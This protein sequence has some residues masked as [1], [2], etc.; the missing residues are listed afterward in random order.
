MSSDGTK[1]AR[2]T[3]TKSVKGSKS[4]VR[5]RC[6]P[7]HR[8]RRSTSASPIAALQRALG[9]RGASK[10]LP[11]IA[12]AS[13][14]PED[15]D[16]IERLRIHTAPHAASVADDAGAQAF[17]VAY[18][19]VF[20]EG[21]F[22]SGSASGRR[23]LAHEIAH[24][25]QQTTEGL[26]VASPQKAEADADAYAADVVAGRPAHVEC[27]TPVRFAAQKKEL[28]IP[29]PARGS[30][31]VYRESDGAFVYVFNAED[32]RAWPD[33]LGKTFATYIADAFPGATASIATEYLRQ[34][35]AT[36]IEGPGRETM[37]PQARI[38]RY[39]AKPDFHALV[40]EWMKN[41]HPQ[42]TPKPIAVGSR[43]LPKDTPPAAG[44]SSSTD[45]PI[46]VEV[47]GP[48]PVGR[49]SNA[50]PQSGEPSKDPTQQKKSDEG[51]SPYGSPKGTDPHGI[52][53]FDPYGQLVI[54][55]AAGPYVA[56]SKAKARVF[57]DAS[58]LWNYALNIFPHHA[59]FDWAL[60][61]D[62]KQID[63]NWGIQTGRIE[64]FIDFKEPGTYVVSVVVS[65]HQFKDGKTLALSS[66]PLVVVSEKVREKE[67]FE[68]SLVGPGAYKP[69]VRDERGN[70]RAKPGFVPRSIQSEI[71]G[72][73][74]ALAAIDQ[75]RKD[76]RISEAEAQRSKNFFNEQLENLKT[77]EKRVGKKS[78]T[79]YG[80][81]L[82]RENSSSQ[83][84][85]VF[86]NQT[87][88][89][90]TTGKHAYIDVEFYDSTAS[91][92][93]RRSM[94]HGE[95]AT[96]ADQPGAYADA[97]TQAIYN[98]AVQWQQYNEYP[99][100]T[101]HFAVQLIERNG[102]VRQWTFDTHTSR[103][104]AKEWIS[105]AAAVGG[106][107]LLAASVVTGGATAPVGVLL[108]ESAVAGMTVGL[109]IASLEERLTTGTFHF[110]ARFVMDMTALVTAFVGVGATMR[111]LAAPAGV[112]SNAN[113]GTRML[114]FNVGAGSFN[115]A[116]MT[117]ETRTLIDQE[118]ASY[119]AAIANVTDEAQKAD[120]EEKHRARLAGIMGAACVSGGIILVATAVA[121]HSALSPKPSVQEPLPASK[122]A[123][124]GVALDA[125]PLP[126]TQ[127]KAQ[128]DVVPPSPPPGAPPPPPSSGSG[129]T[130]EEMITLYHGTRD[131]GAFRGI[132]V[133]HQP[134]EH[135]DFGQ[136]F[137]V[138]E[139]LAVA[140]KSTRM[141]AGDEGTGQRYV[142]RWDVPKSKLGKIVDVR[143]G[144]KD[145]AAWDKFLKEPPF[146]KIP[147][148]DPPPGM[149]TNEEYISGPLGIGKRGEVFEKFL[150]ANNL[151]DADTVLGEIGTPTTS[152]AASLPDRVS[153]QMV[154]RS[155]KVADE[156]N[157]KPPPPR[158]PPPPS[159]LPP[160]GGQTGPDPDT[161]GLG[162]LVRVPVRK[163]GSPARVL[164]IGA[165]PRQTDLGLPPD[166]HQTGEVRTPD[167]NLT[168]VT[169]TDVNPV[170][171]N[172][173]NLNAND[174]IPPDM[175]GRFDTVIINNPKG[176]T[177]DIQKI[178]KALRPGGRIIVQGRAP[179]NKDFNRVV[180]QATP[181]KQPEGYKVIGSE[182]TGYVETFP[183]PSRP[184]E[185]SPAV[186]GSGFGRTTGA[187]FH[188]PVNTRVIFEKFYP[189]PEGQ[190]TA[191]LGK[192][193]G[194]RVVVEVQAAKGTGGPSWVNRVLEKVKPYNL[195]PNDSA[196]VIE[197]ATRASG[198]SHGLRATLPDGTLAVTSARV[199]PDQFI[200]GVRTDGT[201][202]RGTGTI[203]MGANV[204]GHV[205]VSNV[206]WSEGGKGQ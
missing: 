174:D 185:Q 195:S 50:A 151:T 88:R 201:I 60:Y 52:V 198:Y 159:G 103:K 84:L 183:D 12:N 10:L 96:T 197:A 163:D 48:P 38:R 49:K 190:T 87:G 47:R 15:L 129:G 51:G 107:A 83:V 29:T 27:S 69:F 123:R 54:E 175:V 168:H 55:P 166:P 22:A 194:E 120:M 7:E 181:L 173:A 28:D 1:S 167:P 75:L 67:V 177:P 128:A 205:R 20:A 53:Q 203:E 11:Y 122:G 154:I 17:A 59:S 187:G 46:E 192:Q 164:E 80:T 182:E 152:G 66:D 157:I 92:E 115:F 141:R 62:G 35:P 57:F 161:A 132:N 105:G 176:Y 113:A 89:G 119:F 121:A 134:G 144:G 131:P 179:A 106:A 127:P 72:I 99:D 30:F 14:D 68:T 90:E 36:H 102:E 78:Y 32:A 109:V 25:L 150:R 6:A 110:D 114:L 21:M 97:E 136:G 74:A 147:G 23:L 44:G 117:Y 112:V 39:R 202:V 100:G 37:T 199:G 81:F 9:N 77:I 140:E 16:V 70:L 104:T 143:A 41:N 180:K 160:A 189:L 91:I 63:T 56:N 158:T 94:G 111:A 145:R 165:G 65:S 79:I 58:N 24:V 204:P 3:A 116:L 162:P 31:S 172:V 169:A 64:Y 45:A 42:F 118:N 33:E 188:K 186:M 61:K 93:P 133:K 71:D 191:T 73:N 153:T 196:G 95:S 184:G 34:H 85:R 137:Y 170:R 82:N 193:I 146:P 101:I 5:S 178:G 171:A 2:T 135:Q 13:I 126:K 149:R 138:S 19:I 26:P 200:V 108:L 142:F 8:V 4:D 98:M 156:L 148:Y 18:D 124:S 155:Q 43:K 206:K 76:G 86:M 130:P 139:D 125:P 40:T